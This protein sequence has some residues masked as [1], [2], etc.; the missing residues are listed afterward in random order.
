MGLHKIFK[1]PFKYKAIENVSK[2]SLTQKAQD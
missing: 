1:I 2:E